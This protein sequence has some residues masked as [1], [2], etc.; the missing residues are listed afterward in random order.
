MSWRRGEISRSVAK[1]IA[2]L[3]AHGEAHLHASR[4]VVVDNGAAFQHATIE[5]AYERHLVK[6]V[7]QSGRVRNRRKRSVELT[8]IGIA[9]ARGLID[10]LVSMPKNR[11]FITL[12]A[13]LMIQEIVEDVEKEKHLAIVA[14]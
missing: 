10:E 1:L 4:W 3:H 9:T 11:D 13:S 14:G 6:I 5:A 2:H 8:P 7:I 12:K